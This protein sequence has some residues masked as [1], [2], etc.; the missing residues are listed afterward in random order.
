MTASQ[1]RAGT[2]ARFAVP[3]QPP[4][5][6]QLGYEAFLDGHAVIR[7]LSREL[8]AAAADLLE[9]ATTVYVVDQLVARPRNQELNAGSSWGRELWVEIPVREPQAWD[10]Q[11]S[12]LAELLTWLTDDTWDLK[13]AQLAEGARPLD[14]SQ[15]F[16]FDTIP[17]NA[18]HGSGSGSRNKRPAVPHRRAGDDLYQSPAHLERPRSR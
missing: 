1:S 13:F 14:A 2:A 18:A 17:H 4:R 10:R 11:A 8:P 5:A 15:G 7:R 16:L 9:I 3:G 12:R 6:A